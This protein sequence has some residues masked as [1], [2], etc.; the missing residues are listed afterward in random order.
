MLSL[1][2]KFRPSVE[3]ARKG[4][5]GRQHSFSK[6]PVSCLQVKSN[7]LASVKKKL[8]LDGVLLGYIMLLTAFV[9]G[10]GV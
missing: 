10:G 1:S 8:E 2:L 7:G 6:C 5:G 4:G 9:A 3:K